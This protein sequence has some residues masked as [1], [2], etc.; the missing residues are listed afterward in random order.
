MILK[1]SEDSPIK[2]PHV[3]AIELIVGKNIWLTKIR[4]LYL[5]II[6]LF[7]VLYNLIADK[8]YISLRNFYLIL[9]LAVFVNLTFI[10]SIKIRLKQ[11]IKKLE[12]KPLFSLAS[13]QLDFDLVV[14]SLLIFFSGGFVSPV[15]VLFIF[16]VMISTFFTHYKKA[17]RNTLTA[18]V[19]IVVIFFKDEGLIVSSEK[20]TAMI[21]FNIIL[22][23]SFFISAYL[24]KNLGKNE[25]VLQELLKKTRE[26]SVT[27]G[28]TGLYNQS[29]FFKLLDLELKKS[30]KHRLVFSLIMFDVDNFKNY[31]DNNGHIRGSEALNKIGT[32]MRKVFRLSDMLAKYGG[33]EFVVILPQTDK[34]GAFLAADRLRETVEQESFVG[35]EKQPQGCITLSIGVASY[36][37][38][39]STAEEILD[40]ADKALYFAKESGKNKTIL[41]SESIE[42]PEK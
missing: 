33:D 36:P 21:G 37:T 12:Y 30:E 8:V 7:F 29:H 28:L 17:F 41:Y 16:Y 34:V 22:L 4:W 6:S 3:L 24:T 35:R 31:N 38:H 26:L 25:K 27:D 10:I 11:P 39:G 32:L 1:K 14:L 19:L 13:L 23:F 9:G 5:V 15:T 20:L 2:D 40:R 18:I 42:K